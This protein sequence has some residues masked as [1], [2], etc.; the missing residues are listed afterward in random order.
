MYNFLNVNGIDTGLKY[1]R[2]IFIDQ[3][4]GIAIFC[5]VVGH[6]I[7]FNTAAPYPY[8]V[9]IFTTI[10]SSFNM[11][12]FFVISGFVSFESHKNRKTSVF[13]QR[14]VQRL[15]IPYI[16]WSLCAAALRI[17]KGNN[18]RDTLFEVLIC[19][20]SVWYLLTLF[21]CSLPAA[22]IAKVRGKKQLFL[23]ILVWIVIIL[24]PKTDENILAL[25]QLEHFYPFF[26]LG[27]YLNKKRE[28]IKRFVNN[29]RLYT[30]AVCFVFLSGT[31]AMLKFIPI[32]SMDLFFTKIT[33]A[34]VFAN[35]LFSYIWGITGC[36]F[37][38]VLAKSCLQGGFII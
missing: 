12:L 32:H 35:I 18:V 15:L 36:L 33:N 34:H 21:I 22:F 5:V 31:A 24:L 3:L 19:G 30:T 28:R 8:N 7:A 4:R 16:V 25:A 1:E 10:I 29:F 11:A 23:H 27:Y 38:Y 37:V 17:L 6:F 20:W 13:L 2:S 14:R 26:V 9:T